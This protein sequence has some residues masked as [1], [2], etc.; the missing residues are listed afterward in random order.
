MQAENGTRAPLSRA[1]PFALVG[2]SGVLLH[3]LAL[4]IEVEFFGFHYGFASLVSIEI[5][6]LSNYFLNRNWTWHD[7]D[8]PFSLVNYHAVTA[9]G[10]LVQW[11]VMIFMVETFGTHYLVAS[12]AGVI[13]AFGWNFYAN[14]KL[15][16]GEN[17][18]L[19]R[20]IALY[21]LAL[22]IQI[23]VALVWT[24]PWD[25]Y[26]FQQSVRDFIQTG[27][28]PYQVSSQQPQYIFQGYG[29]P[30]IAQWYAYPPLAFIA[31]LFSYGPFLN[32]EPWLARILIKVP[33][34]ISTLFMA[35]LAGKLVPKHQIKVET[36]LLLNPLTIM[37]AAGWGQLEPMMLVFLLLMFLA[38]KRDHY[39][40]AGLAFGAA[41]LVKVFPLYLAPLLMITIVRRDGWK[42]FAKFFASASIII[43]AVC[44]PFFIGDPSG[45]YHAVFGMHFGRPPANFAPL[46]LLYQVL[47]RLFDGLSQAS[48]APMLSVLGFFGL[49]LSILLAAYVSTKK[50]PTQTSLYQF[51]SLTIVGALLFGKVLNEQYFLMITALLALQGLQAK[52]EST[53]LFWV[54]SWLVASA[55]IIGNLHFIRFM[56]PDI[57]MAI[58]GQT[59]QHITFEIARYFGTTEATLMPIS[60]VLAGIIVLPLLWFMARYMAPMAKFSLR[61]TKGAKTY[62][63][64]IGA[65]LLFSSTFLIPGITPQSTPEVD[66][67]H[68]SNYAYYRTNWSNPLVNPDEKNGNWEG[69]NVKP[70]DGFYTVTSH[71][72]Q[73]DFETLAE[74]GVAGIIIQLDPEYPLA[75]EKAESIAHSLGLQTAWSVKGDGNP[76]LLHWQEQSTIKVGGKP[77]I[78][79][80]V[81]DILDWQN[82]EWQPIVLTPWGDVNVWGT[83]MAASM[84]GYAESAELNIMPWNDFGRWGGVEPTEQVPNLPLSTTLPPSSQHAAGAVLVTAEDPTP[85]NVDGTTPDA[86][87]P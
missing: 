2:A 71:K 52:R 26:V 43:A 65:T 19:S 11:L 41:V 47:P 5:A 37:I 81:D 45:F 33:F 12:F 32:A 14:N 75:A 84:W 63:A 64:V 76:Q 42:Q 50:Q 86:K 85:A 17:P 77:A 1:L 68:E 4:W 6:T 16:F 53:R 28:T 15:T 44:L 55:G 48:L 70:L 79:L 36:A 87:A 18:V 83:S 82:P 38:L 72:I 31:M 23:L 9:V 13:T 8:V 24:Q 74:L 49:A 39:G 51:S 35:Y 21:A 62:A 78:F 27:L 10:A 58:F 59:T 25:S 54:T 73:S 61:Q 60:R 56:P 67:G 66:P 80:E 34:I 40:M 46:A 3:T 69:I 20:R 29:E 57:A 30:G 7:K 22:F